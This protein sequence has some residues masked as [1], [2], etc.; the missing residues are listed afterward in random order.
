LGHKCLTRLKDAR[1]SINLKLIRKETFIFSLLD[2]Y[3]ILEN[4]DRITKNIIYYM[5]KKSCHIE[6]LNILHLHN[7]LSFLLFPKHFKKYKKY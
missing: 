2:L 4:F 7:L 6:L 3:T 5:K 1:Q